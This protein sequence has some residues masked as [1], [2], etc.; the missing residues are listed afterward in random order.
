MSSGLKVFAPASVANL[1]VGYDILGVAL[2]KPGDEIVV[3]KSD[4]KGLKITK[5]TGDNGLL[6]REVS[7]NTAGV[8]AQTYLDHINES[9]MGIEMEIRKKMP[10]GS[11]L[12][13]SA[14]SA[15]AGVFAVNELLGRPLNR[16]ELLPFAVKGEQIADGAFHGDNVAPSLMGGFVLVKNDESLSCHKIP[17]PSGICF[18]IIHPH[19][20]ILTRVARNVLGSTVALS[21]HVA[22]SFGLGSLILGLYSSNLDMIKAGLNDAIIEPQ[23]ASLIPH[24]YDVKKIAINFGALGCSISGAGPAIFAL[25]PNTGIAEEINKKVE[26]FLKSKSIESTTYLSHVN[27]EGAK[28][29]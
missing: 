2:E 16:R 20:K 18:S 21:D 5:I 29:F 23:R 13:S 12:G 15:V 24:F 7:K 10:F 17:S 25:C 27:T 26:A 22:Q 4:T 14:A 8:A 1:A 3:R 19:I 11:G 28:L 9:E 6:S